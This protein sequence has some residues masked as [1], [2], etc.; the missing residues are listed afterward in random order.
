MSSLFVKYPNSMPVTGYMGS[1]PLIIRWI[2]A[3]QAI[4]DISNIIKN[5]ITNTTPILQN[6]P[7]IT[8]PIDRAPE[9]T[10]N[11]YQ[12]TAYINTIIK[13]AAERA[14]QRFTAALGISRP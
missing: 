5:N 14:D 10:S 13:A 12:N 2:E 3:T 9:T 7:I 6:F 11:K 4:T 1:K 8:S